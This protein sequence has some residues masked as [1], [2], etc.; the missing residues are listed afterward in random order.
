M[1]GNLRSYTLDVYTYIIV[2]HTYKSQYNHLNIGPVTSAH[3]W[4]LI[5]PES[6]M[7]D[8]RPR[9]SAYHC[10]PTVILASKIVR[11]TL[12]IVYDLSW[13]LYLCLPNKVYI[14]ISKIRYE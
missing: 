12:S 4:L 6:K 10:N 13:K 7:N 1:S 5:K 8:K 11:M 9:A 2:Y 3:A 14:G